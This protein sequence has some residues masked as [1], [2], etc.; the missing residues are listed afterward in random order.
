MLSKR[1]EIYRQ[2]KIYATAGGVALIDRSIIGDLT[3]ARMQKD[4][5]NFIEEEW[6][7]YLDVL[8]QEIQL[9]PSLFLRCTATTSLE[10]VKQ[11]GIEAEIKGYTSEYM[12]QLSNAYDLSISNCSNVRHVILDWNDPAI[13]EKGYL[14]N[15]FV[16]YILNKL[17]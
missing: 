6:D 3:F 9:T 10:R 7:I 4:N 11:R 8:N 12:N 13:L 16:E 2:A 17:L 14:T 5:G 1:I 15:A